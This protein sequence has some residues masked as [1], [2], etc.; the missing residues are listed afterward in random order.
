MSRSSHLFQIGGL[1]IL[2]FLSSGCVYNLYANRALN[3]EVTRLPRDP[4]TLVINGTEAVTLPGTGPNAVLLVHGFVGS[5]IDFHDLG[6][7]LQQKGLTVRLMRLP[8][9][10]TFPLEHANTTREQ[11]LQAVHAEYQSLK[12]TYPQVGLIGFSMGGAVAAWYA[13]Q[14]PVDRMVLIAPYFGVTY[15]WYYG[16]PAEFWNKVAGW[17]FPYVVKGEMF[18]CVNR[19][20]AKSQLFYYRVISNK[21][22][23]ELVRLGKEARDPATLSR[24][25]CPVLVL[26]SWGDQASSPH[27][28][29]TAFESIGSKDKRMVWYE[30]SNHHILWDYDSEAAKKEI[31]EFLGPLWR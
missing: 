30:Q 20:E 10:G 14:Q 13:S 15:R 4:Q 22:A 8:G 2:L 23:A 27:R 26:H 17:A 19:E 7:V 24:I 1:V 25:T 9:H 31:V 29:K 28:S 11:F 6:E 3:R 18:T 5:R 12:A 16:V 21:A